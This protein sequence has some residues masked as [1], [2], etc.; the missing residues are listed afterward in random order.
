ML[1]SDSFFVECVA[2]DT[3]I[4]ELGKIFLLIL[5]GAF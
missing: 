5:S 3:E 4:Q 1:D 2:K